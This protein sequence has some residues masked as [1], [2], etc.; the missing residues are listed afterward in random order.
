MK[1]LTI[2]AG[3]AILLGR[4][5]KPMPSPLSD[6]IGAMVRGIIGIREAYLPQCFVK[7]VVEPPAQVLVVVLDDGADRQSVLDAVG[8]GLTRVLPQG[9]HLDVL[10]MSSSDGL[11]STVRGTRMHIHCT[12]PPEPKP[13]WRFW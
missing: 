10:P 3:S 1:P 11:L 2:S 8:L 6:A 5:A 9:R 4:P 12:P 7:S 13:W